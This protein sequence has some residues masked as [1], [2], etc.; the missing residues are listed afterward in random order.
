M[1][2][3][4]GVQKL[5]GRQ[6]EEMLKQI[7]L[8]WTERLFPLT[9]K[10]YRLSKIDGVEING[11]PTVGIKAIHADGRDIEFFFAQETY[12][13]AKIETMVISP[14]HGPEPVL[15]EAIYKGIEHDSYS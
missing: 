12:L 7:R 5:D 4:G 9:D 10:A 2:S 11:R 13:I 3:A 15:R 6:L 14:R 1:S 8:A